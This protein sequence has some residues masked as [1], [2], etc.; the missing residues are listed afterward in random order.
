MPCFL[1][2]PTSQA[3][4]SAR[5]LSTSLIKTQRPSL[6]VQL[7]H[8]GGSCIVEG[9]RASNT[10]QPFWKASSPESGYSAACAGAVGDRHSPT[11]ASVETIEACWHGRHISYLPRHGYLFPHGLQHKGV[12]LWMR[13]INAHW[14]PA[15]SP[16][17]WSGKLG[18]GV[19][20]ASCACPS[21]GAERGS[22]QEEVFN[23]VNL[24]FFCHGRGRRSCRVTP[25]SL[26]EH[27]ERCF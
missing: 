18:S 3:L 24:A 12:H 16:V 20:A 9:L 8:P 27:A 15:V 17:L 7:K 25:F 19:A 13:M 6:E 22:N 4:D 10:M 14:S 11:W 5:F 26:P 1:L 23:S 21:K 2:W